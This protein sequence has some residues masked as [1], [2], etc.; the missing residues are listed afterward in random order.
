[1]DNP[2]GAILSNERTRA[3]VDT[4]GRLSDELGRAVP[5]FLDTAYELLIHDPEVPPRVS[6]LLAD[7]HGLVYEI[8]TV[9]KV[10][11]PALRIGYLMGP[12]GPFMRAMVQR[13]NDAGFSAPLIAQELSSYLLDRHID[14]QLARVLAGYREKARAVGGWIDEYLD[15][16]LEDVRGGRAGFYYY[17]TF[18]D[19]ATTEESPLFRILARTTGD[20]AVD[21]PPKNPNPRVIYIPGEYCVQ[22][23]G[24][25]VEAGTRQMRISY[26]FEETERIREALALIAEGVRYAHSTCEP[27]R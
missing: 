3:L 21:G 17:L 25:L 1:M 8:G 19:T 13:T 6:G 22:P 24:G 26:G 12:D 18:R 7:S 2:T 20:P 15:E 10:L 9:S 27:H 4:A 16:Y 14:G 11:A 5:V 23:G